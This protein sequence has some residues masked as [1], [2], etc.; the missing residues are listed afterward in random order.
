M[1]PGCGSAWKNPCRNTCRITRS[2][3]RV[4]MIRRSRSAAS[5]ASRRDALMAW[6]CSIVSTRNVL[7]PRY[8]TGTWTVGSP[9]NW[10]ANRSRCAASAPKSSSCSILRANSA[11]IAVGR[12]T[13]QPSAWRSSSAASWAIS[14]RSVRTT[15]AMPGRCTFSTTASPVSSIAAWTCAMDAAPS[16]TV[17]MPAKQAPSGRPSSDSITLRISSKGSGGTESWSFFSSSV[18]S[19]G[20]RCVRDES[21]WP[22]FTNVGPSSTKARRSFS[23]CERAAMASWSSRVLRKPQRS[24]LGN[25]SRCARSS[26]P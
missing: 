16:G 10:C 11:T 26:Y 6:M 20:S 13:A 25:G 14:W 19:R 23:G 15:S 17:S 9:A 2:A 24:A 1:F 7:V 5:S 4:A 22:S 8:S 12:W 21:S 18:N 3:M